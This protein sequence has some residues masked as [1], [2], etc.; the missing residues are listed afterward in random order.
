MILEGEGLAELHTHLGGSVASDI[1]WIDRARAGDRA[2]GEGLL[3]VRRARHRVRSARRPGPRRAR[4]DLP[5]DGAHPVLADRRRALGARR[6]RRRVPLAADHDARAP[7]QPDEEKPRRRARPRPHHPRGH[8]RGRPREH[9]VPAGAGRADSD[10]GSH[11]RPAPERDHRREGD[12]LVGP[13]HRRRRHR[14]TEARRR[15]A[16]TT[17]RSSRWSRRLAR[18]GSA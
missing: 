17:R 8:P 16:T 11:L 1:L 6:D 4:P 12:S 5:L 9:R 2:A 18:R 7:V 3:G 10:D 13:R 14:G 15:A